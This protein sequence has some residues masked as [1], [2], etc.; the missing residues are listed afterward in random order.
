M[1][2]VL[3]SSSVPS[4]DAFFSLVI[5]TRVDI[6]DSVQHTPSNYFCILQW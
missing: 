3:R 4:T 2:G 1:L 6:R 5:S